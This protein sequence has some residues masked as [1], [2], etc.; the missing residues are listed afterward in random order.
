MPYDKR[1]H[2]RSGE[3]NQLIRD[4]ILASAS[5][6]VKVIQAPRGVD[7]GDRVDWIVQGKTISSRIQ[8]ARYESKPNFTLRDTPFPGGPTERQLFLYD[9]SSP[10][11]F[12]SAFGN[13]RSGETPSLSSWFIVDLVRWRAQEQE[14]MRGRRLSVPKDGTFFYRYD[15][16][17]YDDILVASCPRYTEPPSRA[18]EVQLAFR[19]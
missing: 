6:H 12:L 4:V 1:R 16:A 14:R 15:V 8:D 18:G 5:A 2:I 9:A 3:Y 10:P 19:S 7:M 11:L 13:M 17:G